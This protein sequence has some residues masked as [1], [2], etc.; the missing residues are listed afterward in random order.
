MA[1]GHMEHFAASVMQMRQ[2]GQ[3]PDINFKKIIPELIGLVTNA[4]PRFR[5][6]LIQ[7]VFDVLCQRTA[8]ECFDTSLIPLWLRSDDENIVGTVQIPTLRSS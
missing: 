3:S 8:I 5:C 7:V 6:R 4:Q 2:L 1:L